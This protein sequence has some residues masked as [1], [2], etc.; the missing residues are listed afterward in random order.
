M[1]RVERERREDLAERDAFSERVRMKD[2]EKT[3]HII[4]RSDKKVKR[5]VRMYILFLF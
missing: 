2:K 3:R 1:Y 5:I 4:E